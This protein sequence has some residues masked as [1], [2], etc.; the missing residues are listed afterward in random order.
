MAINQNQQA[1]HESVV[2]LYE[3]ALERFGARG[4]AAV[5]QLIE[6]SPQTVVNWGRGRG[7]S[8]N[9]ALKIQS[10]LGWS[11][12]WIREGIGP[13]YIQ[14]TNAVVGPSTILAPRVIRR[15]AVDGKI[16]GDKDGLVIAKASPGEFPDVGAYTGGEDVFGLCIRTTALLPRYREGEYLIVAERA[17][18]EGGD[19]VLV[20]LPIPDSKHRRLV[21][22]QFAYIVDSMVVLNDIVTFQ[23][24][25]YPLEGVSMRK[26][27]SAAPRSARLAPQPQ[28]LVAHGDPAQRPPRVKIKGQRK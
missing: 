9:G 15:V 10:K 14:E 11:A 17:E 2:R 4:P 28:S 27:V 13:R 5:A 3:C 23:P 12:A 18:L 1:P 19:D 26:I 20:E 16:T 22:K 21:V 6:E 7:V 24:E 25:S 8:K